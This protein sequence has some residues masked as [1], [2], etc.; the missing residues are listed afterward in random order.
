MIPFARVTRCLLGLLA[1][2]SLAVSGERPFPQIE[3][4]KVRLLAS[5]SPYLLEQGVVFSNHDTLSI[6]PGV[7]VLMGEYAK[8]MFRGFVKIA[9][10]SEKPVVFKSADSTK[11]WNGIHFTSMSRPFEVR[12]LHVA[13]AF[14][15]SVF[16]SKGVFE[17]THFDNNY[18]GLWLD[19]SPNVM[20]ARCEFSGNRFALSVRAGQVVASE[21]KISDNVH[22]LYLE[23][24]G[25]FD[26][27]YKLI[28]NNSEADVRNEAE[29]MAGQ[30][31]KVNRSIWQH[32]ETAF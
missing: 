26:G 5:E 4:G 25:S 13:N 30:G 22:G 15:N 19:E 10:T 17:D 31:R 20:L 1:F 27:D 28:S 8:I 29:E 24:G 14:R 9:G 11:S 16:R 12:H 23:S 2:T 3:N 7:T 21:T 32:L 6:E 18:Y